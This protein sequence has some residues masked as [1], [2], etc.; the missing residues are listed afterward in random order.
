MRSDSLSISAF[1]LVAFLEGLS[2]LVLLFIAMPLKYGFDS[3]GMVRVTGMAHGVLFVAYVVGVLFMAVR[4]KWSV[5]ITFL[6]MLA[7]VLPFGTFVAEKKIFN[8]LDQAN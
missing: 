4:Y 8:K 5:R 2:F 6:A 3:P 1:R 7:S